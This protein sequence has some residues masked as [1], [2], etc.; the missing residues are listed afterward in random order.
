MQID[1]EN[2]DALMLRDFLQR[3]VRELDS[4][5]YATESLRFKDVL[6]EDERQLER[7]LEAVTTALKAQPSGPR[8]WEARDSVPDL[9]A[10]A[11]RTR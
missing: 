10:G 5:I 7:I 2:Q 8:D 6:R 3:R 1:L 4:E 11:D 9:D